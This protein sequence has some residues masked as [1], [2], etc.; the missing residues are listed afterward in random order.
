M[1]DH[2]GTNGIKENGI[3]EDIV[4]Q[5]STEGEEDERSGRK[6]WRR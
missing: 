4:D 6:R 3:G 5:S 1:E 2:K